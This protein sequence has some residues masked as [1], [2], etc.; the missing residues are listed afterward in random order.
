MTKIKLNII[1]IIIIILS[2]LTIV[3]SS[4]NRILFKLNNNIITTVDLLNEI[5]FLSLINNEFANLDRD[6][7]IEIAKNY[8]IRE[9]VKFIEIS[10]FRNEF[11]VQDSTMEILLKNYFTN[12]KINKLEDFNA[13]FKKNKLD[14]EFIKMKIIL[15]S[16]WKRLIY[17]KYSKNIKINKEE[18]EADVRKM[19]IQ[20]EYLLSEIV[21][22]INENE[23]FESKNKLI[24]KTIDD[25]SFAEAAFIFSISDSSKSGGNLGW[26]KESIL[27]E[28]IKN[29]LRSKKKSE[30]TKAI[31]IPGGFLILY[32]EDIREVE[33]N[34]NIDNE[35]KNI[36]NKKTNDQLDLFS[37][38][39]LNKI[40][41]T[42]EINEF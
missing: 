34:I 23:K 37:N 21:F 31:V 30:F 12:F 10:K 11:D 9:K 2:N 42:I 29:E 15:D 14:M 16:M 39:Y 19:K 4:E 28:K 8:Q 6:K 7:K 20:K 27:S 32:I 36:I 22:N 25:T 35:I 24:N 41:K 5:K 3:N 1:Y 18:I 33:R 17:E 40:K 38:I 26:V 13:F